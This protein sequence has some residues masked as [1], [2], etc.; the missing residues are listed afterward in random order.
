MATSSSYNWLRD[1]K[2]HILQKDLITRKV[3]ISLD[4]SICWEACMWYGYG[5]GPE[6]KEPVE[7]V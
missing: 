7:R 1:R 5:V 3:L 6:K 4:N 2:Q